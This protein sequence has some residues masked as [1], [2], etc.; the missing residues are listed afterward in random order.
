[1]AGSDNQTTT[2][3]VH[4]RCVDDR[5]D[6]NHNDNFGDDDNDDDDDD[7]KISTGQQSPCARQAIVS[8]LVSVLLQS[9]HQVQA[10][11]PT[12]PLN[13]SASM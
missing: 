12:N 3:Y 2:L 10:S 8:T 5:Y 9:S 11:T 7:Q 4:G 6:R 1:M 13:P